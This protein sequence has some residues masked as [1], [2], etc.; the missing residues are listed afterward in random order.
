[1]TR[2][3]G[4]TRRLFFW[5]VSIRNSL[6]SN[7][8][9]INLAWV[10][11]PVSYVLSAVNV[12]L[13]PY[14]DAAVA[15]RF[16][17]TRYANTHCCLTFAIRFPVIA[18]NFVRSHTAAVVRTYHTA[19]GAARNFCSAATAAV[20]FFPNAIRET[21]L[22]TEC[23]RRRERES[24]N[25]PRRDRERD[26]ARQRAAATRMREIDEERA[27]RCVFHCLRCQQPYT[28]GAAAK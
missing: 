13:P 27:E 19:N 16:L 17:I 20:I 8:K 14:S 21:E 10:T 11:V 15:S 23:R 26:A 12:L 9:A 7:K 28:L 25:S 3:H 2:A 1:M 24:L 5:D 6:R 4:H 18:D 22:H